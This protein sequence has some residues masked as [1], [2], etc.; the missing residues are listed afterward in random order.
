MAERTTT[1]DL[2]CARNALQT[3]CREVALNREDIKSLL[4]I[5]QIAITALEETEE[6]I[7]PFRRADSRQVCSECFSKYHEHPRD[8]RPE[9]A[10]DQGEPFLRVLCNGERVKL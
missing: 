1:S 2:R 7:I 5:E 3:I 9:A 10:S 6:P 8:R 4:T